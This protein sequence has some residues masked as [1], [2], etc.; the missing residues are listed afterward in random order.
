M[1][2]MPKQAAD[3]IILAMRANLVT[4]LHGSPG[5]G[6]SDIVRSIAKKLKLHLIDIR[7]AQCDPCDLNY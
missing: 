2:V 3:L 1:E 5:I 6:K 7:L 4:M